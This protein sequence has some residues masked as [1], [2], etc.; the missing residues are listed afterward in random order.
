MIELASGVYWLPLVPPYSIN[1]Y[2]VDDILF[3]AGTRYHPWL[4]R[5]ALRHHR[6]TTHV[7]THAHPD[8]Q[9]GS[10]GVCAALGVPL[11]CSAVEAPVVEQGTTRELLPPNLFNRWLDQ[12][13]SGPRHPVDHVL[14]EGDTVGGF[15]VIETPG[16][17]PGHLSFWRQRDRLLIAGDVIVNCHPLTNMIELREPLEIFTPNPALNRASARKL[18]ALRPRL[19]CMGHGPPLRDGERFCNFVSSLPVQA[20]TRRR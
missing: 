18:A 6:V 2:F 7:L 1:A 10:H 20:T 12:A 8:H 19:V 4:I 15:E 17:S 5:R 11:W 14:R 16:H 3:D 9:G 13:F